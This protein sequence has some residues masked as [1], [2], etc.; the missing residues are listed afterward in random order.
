MLI[1]RVWWWRPW[2]H[3]SGRP[4]G[5]GVVPAVDWEQAVANA[6]ELAGEPVLV[7]AWEMP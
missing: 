6:H 7:A 4:A 3:P 2:E 1:W 5:A